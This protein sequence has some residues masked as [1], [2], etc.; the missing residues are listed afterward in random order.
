MSDLN[1]YYVK[2]KLTY[3]YEVIATSSEQAEEI[4][5]IR[6][7]HTPNFTVNDVE[8]EFKDIGGNKEKEKITL[9]ISGRIDSWN[10]DVS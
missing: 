6:F 10:L 8:V 4:S 2:L 5:R 7:D 9:C 3:E 1:R